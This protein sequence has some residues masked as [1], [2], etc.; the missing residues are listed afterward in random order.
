MVVFCVTRSVAV[1]QTLRPFST[2]PSVS[3]PKLS[4]SPPL[5]IKP[6][7]LNPDSRTENKARSNA[8]RMIWSAFVSG[9]LL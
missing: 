1:V 5:G 9:C 8:R 6:L 3:K 7:S 2:F 4:K